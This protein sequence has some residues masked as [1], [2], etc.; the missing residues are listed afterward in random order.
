M[1]GTPFHIPDPATLL[2]LY[3]PGWPAVKVVPNGAI[4]ALPVLPKE[5]TILREEHIPEVWRI[6]GTQ[7]RHITSPTVLDRYG[8]WAMVRVVPDNALAPIPSG[9][10]IN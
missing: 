9:L 3:P 2:R 6:E 1:G 8:G 7:K 5:G 4:A 10:P